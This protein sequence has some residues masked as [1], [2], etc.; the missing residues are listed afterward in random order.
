MQP[1]FCEPF[2]DCG[3]GVGWCTERVCAAC[4]RC[5][6][7]I[8]CKSHLPF[9]RTTY[10][11]NFCIEHCFGLE[12]GG[13]GGYYCT[14]GGEECTTENIEKIYTTMRKAVEEVCGCS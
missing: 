9:P 3:W 11:R 1:A 8:A 2:V 5:E 7:L 14:L 4:H 13:P 10:S 6:W 12:D